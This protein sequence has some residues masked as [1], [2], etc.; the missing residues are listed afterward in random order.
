MCC[1]S[2]H[3]QR[4]PRSRSRA[5]VEERL[6]QR[7]VQAYRR[8]ALELYGT[9]GTANLLGDD[10]DPRGYRVYRSADGAWRELD[11]L[12]PTWLWTDGLRELIEAVREDR[13]PLASLEQDLHIL[14]VLGAA[15]RAAWEH[16][17]VTVTSRF[18]PIDLRRLPEEYPTAHV[19]D[20]TRSPSEQY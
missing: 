9:D 12:D 17:S 19:H 15:R 5:A 7:R 2:L 8:P 6:L 3:D 14:E 13:P 1:V 20:H 16:R 10:W 18:E 4:A 11:S